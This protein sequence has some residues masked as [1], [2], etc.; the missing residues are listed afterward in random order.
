MNQSMITQ[1]L[2]AHNHT[3]SMLETLKKPVYFAYQATHS[4]VKLGENN[5]TTEKP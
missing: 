2:C 5:G 1:T 4:T 3:M